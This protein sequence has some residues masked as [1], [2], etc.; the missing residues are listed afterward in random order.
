MN[1]EPMWA[2]LGHSKLN[3]PSWSRVPR[4]TTLVLLAKCG[5]QFDA[6]NRF[7]RIFK[8]ENKI[9]KYLSHNKSKN[10]YT[11]GN[12]YTNQVVHM[13]AVN[14]L[15]HGLVTLPRNI[16][17]IHNQNS[18]VRGS[19]RVSNALNI[20]KNRGGGVLFGMF[21]RGT[22][23]VRKVRSGHKTL[24][25]RLNVKKGNTIVKPYNQVMNIRKLIKSKTMKP[26]KH[27]YTLKSVPRRMVLNYNL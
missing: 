12:K 14:N 3:S 1:K 23:G 13:N 21:C 10:V 6:N 8:S 4:G 19:I 7:K 16:S 27:K 5:R 22:P 15:P 2:L 20:I 25:G 17:G 18:L 9:A 26:H 11:S 24:L